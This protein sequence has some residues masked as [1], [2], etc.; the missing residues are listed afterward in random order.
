MDCVDR[1]G[2]SRVTPA[3]LVAAGSALKLK[4]KDHRGRMVG[5]RL[6]KH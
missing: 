6:P 1:N 2:D 5:R 4:L 3:E